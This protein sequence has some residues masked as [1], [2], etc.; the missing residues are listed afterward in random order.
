MSL[1]NPFSSTYRTRIAKMADDQLYEAQRARLDSLA[2]L[3]AARTA[4]LKAK[5]ELAYNNA[6]IASL[7][8]EQDN[9]RA[10]IPKAVAI[11]FEDSITTLTPR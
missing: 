10:H 4:V 8:V 11:E 5:A 3:D 6:R 1:W 9:L 7:Q 2:H